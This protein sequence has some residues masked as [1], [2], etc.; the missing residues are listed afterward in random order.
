MILCHLAAN[1][2]GIMASP[3]TDPKRKTFQRA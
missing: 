3:D 2:R 1:G